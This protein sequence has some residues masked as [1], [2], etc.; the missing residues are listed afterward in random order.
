MQM[1]DYVARHTW[2][3][4][5]PNQHAEQ[6]K[7]V[8]DALHIKSEWQCVGLEL[9]LEVLSQQAHL[10]EDERLLTGVFENFPGGTP[11]AAP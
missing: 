1:S 2:K 10:E 5:V 4:I 8:D 6:H 7:V 3:E 9:Q 11:P